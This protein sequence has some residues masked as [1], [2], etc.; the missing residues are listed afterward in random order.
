[1][2]FY[3]YFFRDHRSDTIVGVVNAETK[4][5]AEKIVKGVYSK[6]CYMN[7]FAVTEIDLSKGYCE[8]HY[9]H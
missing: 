8:L 9:G 7:E 2:K 5:E 1:M 3:K 4:E 6:I